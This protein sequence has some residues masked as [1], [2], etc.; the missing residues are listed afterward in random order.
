MKPQAKVRVQ[1]ADQ[2]VSLAFSPDGS[3]LAVG[4][5]DKLLVEVL[6]ARGMTLQPAFSADCTGAGLDLD[7]V[8]WSSDG[9]FLYAGGLYNSKWAW[10]IRKWAD[11]GKGPSR[12]SPQ[13][14]AE[15]RTSCP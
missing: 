10:I 6:E 1:G 8:A 5:I 4:F 13:P 9:R 12:I 2:P 11:A 7:R 15:S 3:R 14:T